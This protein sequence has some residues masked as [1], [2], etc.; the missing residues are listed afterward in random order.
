MSW[1]RRLVFTGLASLSGQ[2]LSRQSCWRSSWLSNISL[3]AKR[4]L[5]ESHR[6]RD[7]YEQNNLDYHRAFDA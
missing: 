3:G 5:L 7:P 1:Q 4:L 6:Q 2:E